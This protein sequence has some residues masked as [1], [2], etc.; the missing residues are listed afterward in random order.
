[1]PFYIPKTRSPEI[2]DFSRNRF[3]P[4]ISSH[5]ILG[6]CMP[7]YFRYVHQDG[8]YTDIAIDRVLR[9]EEN[10][11]RI[12]YYCTATVHDIRQQVVLV[13]H[14]DVSKWSVGLD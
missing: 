4:V 14:K 13:F 9:K 8:T 7:L 10:L 6:E 11:C 2:I 3:V 5:N 12:I 1:M